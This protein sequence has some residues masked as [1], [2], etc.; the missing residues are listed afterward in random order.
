MQTISPA[1]TL[2]NA[3]RFD[4][5]LKVL[6]MGDSLVYG[7]G[8]PIGG[9]WVERLRRF[10]MEEDGPVLY[11][12]GIRGD[13]VAQVSE[14]LEQEF[15]LR[16]EIRNKVPDLLI[17]SVGVNDS[18]RLGRPDGRCFTDELLFQKQVE[19]LLDLAHQL[20]P[21]LFV[22]MVPVNEERMPFLD[23][24]YFNHSDQHRF[25]TI[26]QEACGDRQ[27]PY[28]DIFEIWQQRGTAWINDHLM[29]DG[30]H[31]NVAGYKALLDDI[32]HWQPLKDLTAMVPR[33]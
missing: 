7:Y 30:L 20:C 25:K 3:P 15:R 1:S 32:H 26:A 27:I 22:G 9:G 13:R 23:C 24:F 17:L 18:P 6:A 2:S 28:L 19:Q 21:V 11:N 4:H 10:W 8:D 14:R 12:L 5:P 33:P 16:G 29:A 31:P